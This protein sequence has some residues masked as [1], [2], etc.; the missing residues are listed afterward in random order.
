TP[1]DVLLQKPDELKL[2]SRKLRELLPVETQGFSRALARLGE[3]NLANYLQEKGYF[4]ATVRSHCDPA[5][6][7]GTEV[8]LV[9]DVKPGDRYDLDDI[10]LEGTN[11]ISITDVSDQLQSR[12]ASF[13]GGVPVLK[14]LPLIGGLARGITSDDRIRADRNTIRARLADL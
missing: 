10:R 12:K 7:S 8:K 14:T 6:C 13:V 11:V 3:R 9:Y 1:A 5:D 2:S 4:F